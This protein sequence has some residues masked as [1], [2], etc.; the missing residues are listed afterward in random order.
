MRKGTEI[1]I[2]PATPDD[3]IGMQE[4][5]YQGWLATYPNAEHGITL[6]DIE[7]RYKDRYAEDKIA[8]GASRWPIP[9]TVRPH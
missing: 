6:D 2:A 8:Q 7:D 1:T 3:V 4:V 9:P 5:F